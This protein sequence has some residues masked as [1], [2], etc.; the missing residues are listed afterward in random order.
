MFALAEAKMCTVCWRRSDAA[1][2]QANGGGRAD[3]HLRRA[4]DRVDAN[5]LALMRSPKKAVTFHENL[6]GFIHLL[7]AS[8][9]CSM[10]PT[11]ALSNPPKPPAPT[12]P[13]LS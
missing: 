12:K 7:R 4:L 6:L 2:E 13:S 10:C 11:I 8:Y 3:D 5:L 1:R 9:R